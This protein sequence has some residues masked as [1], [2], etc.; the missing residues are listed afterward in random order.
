MIV[1]PLKPQFY[2]KMI[3]LDMENYSKEIELNQ[4]SHSHL[5]FKKYCEN[6]NFHE[7][8]QSKRSRIVLV[9]ALTNKLFL[10]NADSSKFFI[11]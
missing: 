11:L 5:S 2:G 9:I 1:F 7:I 8:F 10:N 3:S 6:L 4:Q